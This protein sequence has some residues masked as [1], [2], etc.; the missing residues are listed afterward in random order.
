MKH[1]YEQFIDSIINKKNKESSI[2]LHDIIVQKV[3]QL[4]NETVDAK[5]FDKE[6]NDIWS[7]KD[8]EQKR[9]KALSLC[10]KFVFKK[11]KDKI[12]QSV[13]DATKAQEIDKIVTNACLSG[14]GHKVIK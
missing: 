13:K 3:R 12:I 14:E 6:L 9:T 4:M 11:N 8:I 1:L 2:A 7:T 5:K 10:N